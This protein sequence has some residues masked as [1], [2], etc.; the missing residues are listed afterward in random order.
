MRLSVLIPAFNEEATIVAVIRMVAAVRID[1]WDLEIIL[2]DD[3]S[4]DATASLAEDAIAQLPAA[5]LL[6]HSQNRGKGAAVRS[7]LAAASGEYV[8]I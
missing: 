7:G 4:T 6:R 1:G 8:L 2:V 5:S 3:G